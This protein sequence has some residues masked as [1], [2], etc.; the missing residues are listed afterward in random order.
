MTQQY[1]NLRVD[2]SEAIARV[3]L[4]RPE[5]GNAMS[6]EL[7]RELIDA[8]GRARDDDDVRVVVLTGS[9][10]RIFCA[11]GDL[12]GIGDRQDAGDSPGEG[13]NPTA[14]FKAF[15]GLGKPVIGRLNGHAM[16]GGL[17]LAC[18]CDIVIA[19]DDIKLGTPEVNVGLFPMVIMAVIS[20]S[21]G[22]KAALKMYLTGQTVSPAEAVRIGLITEA[23]PREDLDTR[24]DELA[25]LLAS[26]SP[27]GL[28]LGRDAF[29]AQQDMPFEEQLGFLTERLTAVG[30]TEDAREG[31]RA[32]VEKRT[33]KFTGR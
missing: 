3:E 27:I 5:V 28:K 6:P 30:A 32:F 10:D 15:T 23:V 11:G 17:G 7:V 8:L 19:P 14:L 29:Y 1:N 31:V 20:R 12:G 4:H 26:K 9:G 25:R 18:A 2:I 33:P 24:V 21:V 13:G 16:A 22:A